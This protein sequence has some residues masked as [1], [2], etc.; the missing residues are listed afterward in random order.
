[1]QTCDAG[2]SCLFVS[3]DLHALVKMKHSGCAKTNCQAIG[4]NNCRNSTLPILEVNGCCCD[5]EDFCQ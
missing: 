4:K 3:A 5:G 1:V 2:A